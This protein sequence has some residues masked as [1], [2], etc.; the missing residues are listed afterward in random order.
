MREMY[1]YPRTPHIE[2][3][4]KQPGDEDLDSI[5]FSL[6]T[7]KRLVI[8]EKM[9]GS[10]AG[11]SFD[12]GTLRLQSRGHFLTGGPREAQFSLFKSWA[13]SM[14]A[15]LR[16]ILGYRYVMYGEW[17]WVKHTVFYNSLPHYFMEF[18]IYDSESDIWLST[19]RRH[20]MLAGSGITSVKVLTD[21]CFEKQD[22][23]SGL[24]TASS[25]IDQH[26]RAVDLIDAC[27]SVG[28]E[29][30]I[31]QTDQTGLM[32]GLY[33]KEENDNSVL[34]RYKFV[35][36]SFLDAVAESGGHWFDKTFVYN[37]LAASK[38]TF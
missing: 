5:P 34:G 23:L 17:L 2:G 8:E 29:K 32:E 26:S 14:E 18:D 3:S 30:G 1:K 20:T 16:E 21:N 11:V 15:Q 22:E 27:K 31:G 13:W 33:I 12:E 38:T 35:R 4:R 28:Y 37:R 25:F 7:G 24:I 9:D 6:I 10:Q 19:V 36:K